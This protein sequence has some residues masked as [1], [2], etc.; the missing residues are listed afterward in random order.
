VNHRVDWKEGKNEDSHKS[1][2]IDHADLSFC[3]MH[4]PSTKASAVITLVGPGS[5][6]YFTFDTP[7]GKIILF[8]THTPLESLRLKV[9]LR[10]FA[11]ATMP[12]M[13][14]WYIVGNWI[15][16]FQNDIFVWEN[17]KFLERPYI[18]KGDGP[19]MKQRRWFR[20]FYTI[21]SVPRQLSEGAGEESTAPIKSGTCASTAGLSW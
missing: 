21:D 8:Q 2:F 4:L 14:V 15:A 5:L 9:T 13:L 11:D 6:V 18:V 3:G 17:K 7:I 19:M 20:Q 16:Q 1:W 12:R 10:W